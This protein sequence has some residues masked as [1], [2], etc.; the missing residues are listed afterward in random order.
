M[1]CGNRREGQQARRNP[2]RAQAYGS[3]A[4]SPAARPFGSEG[5]SDVPR[6]TALAQRLEVRP[7][8]GATL[9]QASQQGQL[10]AGGGM[11]SAR[12]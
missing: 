5:A 7:S 2:E 4:S 11:H 3:I 10:L 12:C 9:V 1:D 8:P 6:N